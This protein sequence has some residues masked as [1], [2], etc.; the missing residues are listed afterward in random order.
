MLCP[1]KVQ[2]SFLT[3][4][5]CTTRSIILRKC[6]LGETTKIISFSYKYIIMGL[7]SN[8]F[9]KKE[10]QAP[11]RI[12]TY[13]DF[14]TWFQ[15]HE[16]TFADIIKANGNIEKNVFDVIRPRLHQLN[17]D[18][19]YLVG[20]PDEKT[21]ELVFTVDGKFKSI[22]S[23]EELVQAAPA[24]PRWKFTALKPATDGIGINMHGHV[25][26]ETNMWFYANENAD[27]PDEIDITIV[28]EAHTHE[29]TKEIAHGVYIYLD[30]YLGEL[31]FVSSIDNLA[32]TGKD[33][34]H[35]ELVPI[36]KLRD[37]LL[38]REKEFIEKYDG[39]RRNTEQDSYSLLEGNSESGNPVVAT[40]NSD[41]LRWDRKMSHPWILMV[42][43]NYE[44]NGQ[45]MPDE[46][47]LAMMNE[48][49]EAITAELKDE[50]GYINIGRRTGDNMRDIYYACKEFR[51][52]SKVLRDIEK[53][54]SA[55][56]D[57]SFDIYKDKYWRTFENYV[58]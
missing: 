18:I 48:I 55:T 11:V 3:L 52:P 43:I 2:N 14:W 56:L 5:G 23:A 29:R 8:L 13:A 22:L 35:K 37:Y 12:A 32:I 41:V 31:N 47:T 17:D 44:G 19:F 20:M 45:G 36:N 27:Y 53:Q 24:L 46:A 57:I 10:A 50:G 15:Q 1:K 54:Y 25:F 28:H 16:N 4:A 6:C 42:T 58:Q 40:I 26:D 49:E 38:W 34:A 9:G 7:F 30:N 39:T 21:V 33:N 51:T